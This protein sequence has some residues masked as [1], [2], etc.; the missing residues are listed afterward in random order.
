MPSFAGD[1]IDRGGVPFVK[2]HGTQNDFV[3]L[4]DPE[5]ALTLG[6]DTV[7]ALCDRQ[8]GLGA[9]G[10]LR[11]ARAHALCATGV[12]DELPAGVAGDDWFMDYRN[13][14]GSIA[15]MCGNGVRVFAHHLVV[16][17]ALTGPAAAG[18]F[19]VGTRAGARGVRVHCADAVG[20]DVT[21]DMGP[22]TL[23]VAS[24]VQL[25]E[26]SLRGVAVDVGN[27]HL[28]CV[29][30]GLDPDG[31]ARFDLRV[32]AHLDPQ[33]FPAGANL[34]I[35]TPAVDGSVHLRVLERGVGETRSCGTGIVAA[36]AAA[37]AAA[38]GSATAVPGELS[39]TVPGGR[40]AVRITED[41]SYLRGAAVRVATGTLVSGWDLG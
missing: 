41:T 15:E 17:G 9:D 4:H 10:V 8:R 11:V 26:V 6:T 28:A 39:V 36:A 25:G 31:L 5:A 20:A 21:V 37:L 19:T 24:D 3:V 22:A 12:L 16:S 34:E 7:V 27:P 18:E 32:G 13:A 38:A 33:V 2:A 40:L 30:H 14:D 35:I 1:G 29:V 23:G